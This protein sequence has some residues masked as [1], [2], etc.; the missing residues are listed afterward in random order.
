M[1]KDTF[2]G[3]ESKPC[4]RCGFAFVGINFYSTE[5]LKGVEKAASKVRALSDR[6][7]NADGSSLPL[8]VYS[9]E[10]GYILKDTC[11]YDFGD[12]EASSLD[13]LESKILGADFGENYIPIFVGSDHSITYKLVK[14]MIKEKDRIVVVQFDAHSDFIDEYENYPH[15]SVMNEVSK[16][17]RVEKIIHFGIRGNLNSG[18]AIESSREKGNIVI[19]YVSIKSRLIGLLE[20]LKNKKIYITFDIDFLNPTYAPATNCPEPGGPSYEE[21]L[22]LLKMIINA[23]RKVVGMDFVEFNPEC[24]GANLT[25]TTIVN[26][27]ME[28]LSYMTQYTYLTKIGR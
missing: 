1:K 13:E 25:G 4:G 11:V 10:E 12:I 15:G 3:L 2:L 19:P 28:S 26:L 9:P 22:K 18:P 16:L 21:T 17:D 8:K 27:I 24:E 6:Y 23:S 5:Y 20:Y 14:R 7:A